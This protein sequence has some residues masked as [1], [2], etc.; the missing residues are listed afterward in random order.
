MATS[1]LATAFVNIV[2]GTVELE[3]YLKGDLGNQAQ[4]A[5]EDAGKRMAK[6]LADSFKTVGTQM[7][8]IGRQM[9]FALTLPLVGIATAG[10]KTAA[11]F[12]VSMASMQVNSGATGA[13]MEKL[14][15]LAIKMGQ[16]T[17]FSAGDAARAMLELSK[18][19]M[20]PAT[21][22]GGALQSTMKLAA[23]EGMDL[24]QAATIVTQTMNTFGLSAKDTA[25]A[26]DI[27]AAGAVAS[28]ASVQ[29]LADG[30][31]Y[32][33]STAATLKIPL[34][35][36]VTALAALNNAGID[37][38]TAGTSLN[39]FLLRLIPT[40][41]KAAEEAKALGIDFVDATTGGLKPMNEVIKELV[42]TYG[43]MSDA[44][45]TASLKQIFGV[46]GMRAAN[47]LI[48]EGVDGWTK[49][50]G[51]VN[52]NGIANDLANARM[53]GLAGAIE[54]LKGSIDT[55]FLA[56]G[57]RL[58]PAITALGGF[59]MV[60]INGFASLDPSVQG[61]V[62]TIG[63][64]IAVVGPLLVF[65]GNV[66]TA[67]G[68]LSASWVGNTVA[69][70]ANRVAAIAHGVAN[71]AL[72]GYIAITNSTLYANAVAWVYNTGVTIANTA[73]SVAN[74]VGAALTSAAIYVTSGALLANV[75]AWVSNTASTVANTA[76]TVAARVATMA[77]SAAT[78]IATAA[79]WALNAAMSANPIAL[80]IIAIT[81]LI[82]ALVW[83]FTQTEIGRKAWA[84]FTAFMGSAI[85]VAGDAVNNV[86][87][88]IQSVFRTVFNAIASGFEGFINNI[89]SGINRVISLANT[90]LSLLKT[91]TGG[92]VNITV[93]TVP[94]VSIPKLASG[95]FVDR[96]TTALIGEAGPEV[97]T[98]LKD[99]ERMTGLDKK[100][101]PSI[102]YIAAPNQ[103][104]D[105]EQALFQAMR[106]AK[107][108][109]AW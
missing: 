55:A 109:A 74:R 33:G 96:P 105:A 60:I 76:A 31:K 72:A 91:V 46:E 88:A 47:I 28:T 1:A 83:F 36:A 101:A 50:T 41:R 20:D 12:G 49:L 75:T 30:M 48:N 45:R 43:N 53:S 9:T 69:M 68:I 19:G 92:A 51:A 98:P 100:A 17:V 57:D 10:V 32:V 14:R 63:A 62:V 52:K 39:Q 79:Q 2:P 27:M 95:G 42:D 65:L 81:A 58:A 16:D 38:T 3:R 80:V 70:V 84:T 94:K 24:A 22:S 87:K 44:A 26:V 21:I 6:G 37:S 29:E 78:G 5:G 66:T 107:V 64:F 11:D 99:F 106:R 108:V 25:K 15:Q 35:D 97:V 86:W 59:F 40:T 54:Q 89:I 8:A 71:I 102:T 82:A 90:A 18:G 13:E 104:L 7:Q 34:N 103:S 93:P 61:V 67:V 85:K 4:Q 77:A 56:V 23:T 73:A